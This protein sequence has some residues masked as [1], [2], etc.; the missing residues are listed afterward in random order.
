MFGAA[1]CGREVCVLGLRVSGITQRR[2]AQLQNHHAQVGGQGLTQQ[3]T[4]CSYG[5]G[6][7]PWRRCVRALSRLV[8]QDSTEAADVALSSTSGSVMVRWR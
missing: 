6:A 1:Q 3:I 2:G 4:G 7:S 5:R 8:S